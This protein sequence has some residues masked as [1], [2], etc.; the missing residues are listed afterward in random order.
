M[1]NIFAVSMVLQ[2]ADTTDINPD[3]KEAWKVTK[4]SVT[5]LQVII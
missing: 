5:G 1:T 4:A 3:L 2:V